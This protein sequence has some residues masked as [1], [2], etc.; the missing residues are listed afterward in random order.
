[1]FD[2]LS[3]L[4]Y[5]AIFSSGALLISTLVLIALR[6][7]SK[8]TETTIDDKLLEAFEAWYKK[9]KENLPKSSKK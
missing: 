7:I 2:F 6:K 3:S 1:M 9:Y 5:D 8:K 4:N